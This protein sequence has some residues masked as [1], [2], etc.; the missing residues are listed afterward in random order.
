MMSQKGREILQRMQQQAAMLAKDLETESQQSVPQGDEGKAE[1][2]QIVHLSTA[3]RAERGRLEQ[4]RKARGPKEKITVVQVPVK[5]RS[6]SWI[7]SIILSALCVWLALYCSALSHHATNVYLDPLYPVLYGGDAN[8]LR[9][10]RTID[11]FPTSWQSYMVPKSG[12]QQWLT[13]ISQKLWALPT[14]WRPS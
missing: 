13:P 10:A 8:P 12:V 9:A 14:N 3:A 4:L 11:T 1:T 6:I 7:F 5:R 2:E